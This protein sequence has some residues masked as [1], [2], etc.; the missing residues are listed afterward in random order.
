MLRHIEES[1]YVED[2]CIDVLQAIHFI[3]QAWDEVKVDTIRNCWCY[4]KILPIYI[5]AD[6]DLRND[7]DDENS[8]LN[9][10]TDALQALDFSHKM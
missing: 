9:D 7:S 8:V 1:N 5:D 4:T 3:I 10:L 6:T 2:L